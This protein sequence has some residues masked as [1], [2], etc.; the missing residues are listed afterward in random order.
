MKVLIGLV[1]I[2]VEVMLGDAAVRVSHKCL[3]LIVLEQMNQ[4]GHP[5]GEFCFLRK[6]KT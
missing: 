6:E 3:Y 4:R 2:C 5:V 1:F